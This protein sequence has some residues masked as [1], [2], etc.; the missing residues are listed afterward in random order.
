[1]LRL[2]SDFLKF[3]TALLSAWCVS[4]RVSVHR[5]EHQ[6]SQDC[7]ERTSSHLVKPSFIKGAQ[8]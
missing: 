7:D 8:L 5:T 3:M 1:M 2:R 6:D 4:V